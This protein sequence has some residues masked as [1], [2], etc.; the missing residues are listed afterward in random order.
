[1]AREEAC[2][3]VSELLSEFAVASFETYE[4]DW[5]CTSGGQDLVGYMGFWA[6]GTGDNGLMGNHSPIKWRD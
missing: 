1:M 5:G 3:S 4:Q 2:S 6:A